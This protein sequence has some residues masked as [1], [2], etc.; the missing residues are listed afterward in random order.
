M[1]DLKKKENMQ[2]VLLM[3]LNPFAFLQTGGKGS[4]TCLCGFCF[5]CDFFLSSVLKGW[6]SVG[7]VGGE[8]FFF[9]F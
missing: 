7:D 4:F 2:H 3:C 1:S 8:V 5:V 6:D 9:F